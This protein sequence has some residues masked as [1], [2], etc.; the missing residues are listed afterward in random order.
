MGRTDKP[1]KA[2]PKP[3]SKPDKATPKPPVKPDKVT[4]KPPPKPD[5]ATTKPT[6]KPLHKSCSRDTPCP[7]GEVCV[8]F[9]ASLI[10]CIKR[11]PVGGYCRANGVCQSLRC[12]WYLRKCE[13]VTNTDCPGSFYCRQPNTIYGYNQCIAP[14]P[15]GYWWP[16]NVNIPT[17]FWYDW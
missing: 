1:D 5:K 16:P 3:T 10:T 9:N 15:P 4:T 2:T 14:Q 6:T 11:K 7:T 13:C 8:R 17:G 12:S